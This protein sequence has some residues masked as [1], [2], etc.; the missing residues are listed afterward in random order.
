MTGKASGTAPPAPA[1]S[2]ARARKSHARVT[3][4]WSTAPAAASTWNAVST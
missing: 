1:S 4:S 3:M 2:A